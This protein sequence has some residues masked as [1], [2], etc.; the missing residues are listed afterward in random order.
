MKIISGYTSYPCGTSPKHA[1]PIQEKKMKKIPNHEVIFII[2]DPMSSKE[3]WVSRLRDQQAFAS[4]NYG[5]LMVTQLTKQLY[6]CEIVV[7]KDPQ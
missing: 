2:F 5:C 6:H 7:R 3:Y 4:T 1:P